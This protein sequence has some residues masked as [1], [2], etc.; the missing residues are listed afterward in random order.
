MFK[1]N[2]LLFTGYSKNKSTTNKKK[3]PA[4]KKGAAN[5]KKGGSVSPRN[6]EYVTKRMLSARRIKINELRNETDDLG[7]QLAIVQTENRTLRREQHLRERALDKYENEENDMGNVLMKHQSEV[8]VLKEQ[9]RKNKEKNQKLQRNVKD[10]D[11]E[12]DR[13][14][15]LLRKMKGLVEDKEL[16]ERDELSRKLSKAEVL[17]DEKD[18]RVKVS[19]FISDIL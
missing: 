15:K 14:K 16:G 5:N 3:P 18:Q 6:M 1:Q 2:I 7:K 4:G 17:L 10:V 19:C 8:R 12:L 9:L 11:D 13:T